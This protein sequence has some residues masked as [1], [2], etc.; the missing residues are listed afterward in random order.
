[1]SKIDKMNNIPQ[2][3][4]VY[5]VINKLINFVNNHSDILKSQSTDIGNINTAVGEL[6]NT[7]S[8][9]NNRL[10]TVEGK[11]VSSINTR[12]IL[13]CTQNQ[14]DAI[15][16]KSDTT[17]YIIIAPLSLT[18]GT[19]TIQYDPDMTWGEWIASSYNTFG[20]TTDDTNIFNGNKILKHGEELVLATDKIMT[21]E[22]YEWEVQLIK[23]VI[24]LITGSWGAGND[25]GIAIIQCEKGMTFREFVN[26][27][28]NSPEY[29]ELRNSVDFS[30]DFIFEISSWDYDGSV[31]FT[32]EW[33]DEYYD[34]VPNSDDTILEENYEED[35]EAE[36]YDDY[37]YAS[38]ASCLLGDTL[39]TMASGENKY[40]KDIK[41]GEEVLSLDLET[42]EF[43]NR[44]V[45]YTDAAINKSAS[46]WDEWKFNDGTIIKTTHKHR[47]YC[48]ED[49]TFKH[50]DKWNIGEHTYNKDG[51]PCKL[52][53]HIVHNE[54]VNHYKITLENSNNYFANGLLTGDF[55]C[56]MVNINI[57]KK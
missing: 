31:I 57:F 20:F 30:S 55:R 41:K 26:S 50:L 13:K 56:N 6:S 12:I 18:I 25:D 40:I 8:G 49:N 9:I 51:K 2:K 7:V 39:V 1:M 36:E 37:Y 32:N 47:F 43:V 24:G 11:Y 33:G 17:L 35:K 45:I 44:K 46:I 15:L 29:I 4:F 14:Y 23:V 16:V 28:Y 19:D 53:D 27:E 52:I 22:E 5:N 10:T 48:I 42:G 38:L 3:G 34:D 21:N 54:T